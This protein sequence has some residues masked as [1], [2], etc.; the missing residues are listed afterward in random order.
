MKNQSIG[1]AL[2][3]SRF[4][5][6]IIAINGVNFTQSIP[7]SILLRKEANKCE[8][9]DDVVKLCFHVFCGSFY[10][11]LGWDI[12]PLQVKQ[13]LVELLRFVK[14]LKPRI[15]LEI[16][17]ARGGTLFSFMKVIPQDGMAI[18]VD[19]PGGEFGGGYTAWRTLFYKSFA[20][21]GQRVFLIRGDSHSP[22]T[23]SRIKKILNKRKV[24]FLFI[25]GD[26]S[27]EGVARDFEMYRQLVSPGG[28]I[29]L[30]DIL[31]HRPFYYADSLA[32]VDKLWRRIK[33]QYPNCEIIGNSKQR[34]AG[35][36]VVFL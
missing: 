32:E 18:S 12:H 23:F 3:K 20:T 14:R 34:W 10:K 27:Y 6:L 17:T 7:T 11:Y 28:I 36:G 4:G 2:H 13:E 8:N 15:I 24:D 31:P 22:I 16:G 29:A 9:I 26:H 1:F 19:L 33:C 21:R 25:D 30:H 35:I 5:R